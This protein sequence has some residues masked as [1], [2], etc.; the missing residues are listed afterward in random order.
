MRDGVQ[1]K[2]VQK[3]RE[4]ERERERERWREAREP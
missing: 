3:L 4:R 2:R 1:D